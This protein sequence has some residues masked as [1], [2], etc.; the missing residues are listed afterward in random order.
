[1]LRLISVTF[2]HVGL[3]EL[4]YLIKISQSWTMVKGAKLAGASGPKAPVVFWSQHLESRK[5]QSLKILY[6]HNLVML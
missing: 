4:K 3:V 5:S 1:M 2:I 6:Y